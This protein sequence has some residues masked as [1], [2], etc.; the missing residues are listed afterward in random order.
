MYYFVLSIINTIQNE[1]LLNQIA[2]NFIFSLKIIRFLFSF[3]VKQSEII[4]EQCEKQRRSYTFIK[5]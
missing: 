5:K 4:D 2:L 1:K 3:V